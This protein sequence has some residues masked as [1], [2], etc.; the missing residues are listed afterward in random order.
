VEATR[1][2]V[3][4][5]NDELFVTAQTMGGGSNWGNIREIL[6]KVERLISKY[7]IQEAISIYDLASWKA[8]YAKVPDPAKHAIKQFLCGEVD[9]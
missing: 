6:S 5:G 7:E 1:G 3:E 4:R 9:L 2:V 8:C